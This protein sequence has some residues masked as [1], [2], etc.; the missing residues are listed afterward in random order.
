MSSRTPS[1]NPAREKEIA[2]L[3]RLLA[4]FDS[5]PPHRRE[6]E[7]ADVRAEAVRTMLAELRGKQTG[8]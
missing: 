8:V 3:E 6:D 2:R 7:H 5:I 1:V 4:E